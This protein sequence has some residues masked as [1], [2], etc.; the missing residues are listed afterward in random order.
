MDSMPMEGK[1]ELG[2]F[3]GETKQVASPESWFNHFLDFFLLVHEV[4]RYEIELP[5]PFSV[6]VCCRHCLWDGQH[7]NLRQRSFILAKPTMKGHPRLPGA[8]SN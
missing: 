3:T 8:F 5:T 6:S 2:L 1:R 4:P 7:P